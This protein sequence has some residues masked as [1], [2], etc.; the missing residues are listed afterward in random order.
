[1]V[2]EKH[3]SV[4]AAAEMSGY[5][6]Q[7]LRRLLRAGRPK[8]IKIGQG[9]LIR[10]SSLEAHLRRSQLSRDQRWDPQG[11]IADFAKGVTG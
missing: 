9:W 8:G 6:E 10:L 1:M 4:W 5:N 11:V 2:L 3:P 7:Y